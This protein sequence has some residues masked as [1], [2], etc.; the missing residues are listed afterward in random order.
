VSTST[1]PT[2]LAPVIDPDQASDSAPATNPGAASDRWRN[3]EQHLSAR[4]LQPLLKFYELQFGREQLEELV[5]SLGT[6]MDVLKDLDAWFSTERFVELNEAMIDATGDETL[7]HLAGRALT[8][9]GMLGA[10]RLFMRALANPK[11]A[12]MQIGK[13]SSRYNNVSEWDI[14]QTGR[15]TAHAVLRLRNDDAPDHITFCQNR[16]GV[17][18]AVPE[19]FDLPPA[20]VVHPKCLHRGDEACE[21]EIHWVAK[22]SWTRLAWAVAV[23]VSIATPALGVQGPALAAVVISMFAGA[24]IVSALSLRREREDTEEFTR[25]HITE[26][27]QL[28]ERNKRRA[29]EL[30]T[31]SQVTE[32]TRHLLD[33]NEL[34]DAVLSTLQTQLDYKRV[35]L[36]RVD[37]EQTSLSQ[38]RSLGF[39]DFADA[40]ESLDLSLDPE[41]LDDRLFGR[42]L[43]GG[44]A[45]LIDDVEGYSAQLKPENAALLQTVGTPGFVAAPVEGRGQM[46]GLLVVDNGPDGTTLGA[47]DRNLLGSVAAVLGSAGSNARLYRQIQ[48]ELM[49]NRKF[50][51]YLPEQVVEQVR[52]HPEEALAL[53]G[54]ERRVAVM[55]VDIAGFTAMS[56]EQTPAEVVQGLNAW[57]SITDPVIERCN[58]IVDKRMGDGILVVF[59]HEDDTRE[60]RHPV[61]RAA[62]AGVGLHQAL[63]QARDD[64]E[65]S[66]PGFAQME[67]R[68]AIHYGTAIVGN[69]GSEQRMEYTVI[70]DTVNTA[71]RVE[72]KTPAG[73]VWLS[74]EAVRAVGDGLEGA[75]FVQEVTLR[76]RSEKTQLYS[77]DLE[78]G[79]TSTGTWPV[80]GGLAATQTLGTAGEIS[81]VEPI[82]L[83]S[84]FV[85]PF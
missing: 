80:M 33:E 85:P 12:Y 47:R 26:L 70:G 58:G 84:D 31:I 45:V 18:E 29:E 24:A 63:E 5:S 43:Q 21:Y 57:F 25:A 46:L 17:F 59:L 7:P 76:G 75:E 42:I 83:N 79:A 61:E 55:F 48:D 10:E 53:G 81:T 65:K 56:T 36:L 50:R 14:K 68:C 28:L 11:T 44:Q 67:I 13:I 54:T 16:I 40:V 6:T 72:E 30:H 74:G 9:P 1:P 51:Q 23:G 27:G 8:W 32:A 73:A 71:A 39:G 22:R 2:N 38:G 41:G 60:G 49:I 35:L 3:S 15:T 4:L 34:I 78:A 62:A 77:I 20:R 69:M 64:L 66:V 37:A 19:V 52:A 82:G